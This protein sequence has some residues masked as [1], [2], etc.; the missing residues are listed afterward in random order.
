MGVGIVGWGGWTLIKSIRTNDW[1]VTEGVI[2]SARQKEHSDNDGSSTYSAEVTYTYQ[3]AGISYTGDKIAIGQMSSSAAYAQ[4]V[5]SRYPVGQKVSVHYSPTDPAQAVLE[6]GIHGGTWI[7]FAVGTVFALFGIMFLQLMRNAATAEMSGS[8]KSSSAPEATEGRETTNK[9]PVL[10]GLIFLIAGGAIC[11]GQP[12]NGTPQWILYAAGGLFGSAGLYILLA[13]LENKLFSKL[14]T[15]LMLALF[16][17][18][19]HWVSFGAGERLGTSTTPFS[20][21]SGVNVKTP[22]AIFTILMDVVIIA[23]L[24]HRFSKRRKE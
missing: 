12:S 15:L 6:T 2:Q 20:S 21:R 14:A 18:I 5:L 13:R 8:L 3:I 24:V 7:C 22:F 10:L 19:F 11:F 9:P 4:S 16:L 17:A 23:L 1:P